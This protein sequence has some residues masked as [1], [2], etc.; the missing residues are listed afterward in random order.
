[1]VSKA[2]TD[3]FPFS[4]LQT[5]NDP[6]GMPPFRVALYS[7]DERCT[8]A[9]TIAKRLCARIINNQH[10]RAMTEPTTAQRFTAA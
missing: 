8:A 10:Y 9:P 2:T 1:M 7:A 4:D 3:R 6:D 5:S